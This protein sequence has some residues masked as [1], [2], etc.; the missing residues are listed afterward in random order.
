MYSILSNCAEMIDEFCD[1]NDISRKQAFQMLNVSVSQAYKTLQGEVLTC[2]DF[3]ITAH[4]KMNRNFNPGEIFD[5]LF[6]VL[7]NDKNYLN[8]KNILVMYE[9][10]V[11]SHKKTKYTDFMK[12]LSA[13]EQNSN[14][15]MQ[16]VL[17]VEEFYT[18][19]LEKLKHRNY[20]GY[21]RYYYEHFLQPESITKPSEVNENTFLEYILSLR[22]IQFEAAYL[23]ENNMFEESVQAYELLFNRAVGSYHHRFLGYKLLEALYAVGSVKRFTYYFGVILK[24]INDRVNFPPNYDQILEHYFNNN[25]FLNVKNFK[26]LI[27]YWYIWD[28]H[29]LVE[30]FEHTSGNTHATVSLLLTNISGSSNYYIL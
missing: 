4:F 2:F 16:L 6:E 3:I 27:K 14:N 22:K 13:K 12:K 26:N 9:L 8:T 24:V 7:V 20:K 25:S 29:K 17:D 19:E 5:T 30:A 21:N 15:S 23:Y 11:V 10:S 18:F 28:K 1:D